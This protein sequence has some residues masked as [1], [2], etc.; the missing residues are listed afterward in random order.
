MARQNAI[1]L[2]QLR[3]LAAINLTGSITAAAEL[4]N[5]TVPAVSTQLKLLETN[6]G[7]KLFVRASN[8]SNVS[9]TS[10]ASNTMTPQGHEVLSAVGRI[11]AALAQCFASVKAINNGK[12]GR[13]SL[14]VIS[15]GK[16]FAPRLVAL[17]KKS[18][19]DIQIDLMIGNRQ[20][21]IAALDDHSIDLGIMGRPPRFPLVEAIALG[22]NP[23]ILIAPPGHELVNAVDIS[24]ERLLAETFIMRETGSGTRILMER[25]LDRIGEGLGYEHMEFSTNET[26]KQAVIAGLGIALISAHTVMDALRAN[27]I[28]TINMPG[29]PIVRRW[30][31]VRPIDAI[32][33]PASEKIQQLLV[34]EVQNY[35]PRFSPAPDMTK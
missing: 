30:F 5:L 23:H 29:L 15:T 31:L 11:E 26:I 22:P 1:T 9:N 3:A 16:Y 34:G 8:A 14:G 21:M 17:A 27:R 2:K 10:N 18:L 6:I 13:V 20:R 28:T 19:P 12:S 7:A 4:L 24:P 25:Y 32:P 33:T 35:L